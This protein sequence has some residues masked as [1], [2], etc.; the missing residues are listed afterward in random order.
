MRVVD[1]EGEFVGILSLRDALKLAEEKGL[2]LI[3]IAPNAKPPVAKIIDYDKFRYQKSKEAKKQRATQ[4]TSELKQ[5]RI[6][7]RAAKN[8]L[9]IK[10]RQME[11]FVEEGHKI[12][13]MLVLKG[14]EK[15][16]KEWAMQKLREFLASIPFE[17][18]TIVE[19]KFGGR[20]LLTQIIKK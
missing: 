18:K 1:S 17:Y 4:K 9:D 13:I 16:N 12:E 6:G 3:E 15:Y 19:P 11:K 7:A 20:G 10:I 2:D 14:R 5:I 8:D